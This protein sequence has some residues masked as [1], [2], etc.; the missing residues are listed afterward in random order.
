MTGFPVFP[1]QIQG[2]GHHPEDIGPVHDRPITLA[3]HE[4]RERY[5]SAIEPLMRSVMDDIN[6]CLVFGS[7]FATKA[8]EY[9]VA[10]VDA[11][12]KL[13]PVQFSVPGYLVPIPLPQA[14]GHP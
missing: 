11:G 5:R 2:S 4:S 14:D 10:G 3:D 13:I 8:T 9:V 1:T 6:R 7:P 12:P